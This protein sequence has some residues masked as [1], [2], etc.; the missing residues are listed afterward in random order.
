M[1]DA[2]TFA[3]AR[4]A[5]LEIALAQIDG[6]IDKAAALSSQLRPLAADAPT[7]IVEQAGRA[8]GETPPGPGQDTRT[9]ERRVPPAPL[10]KVSAFAQLLDPREL[11]VLRPS[12]DPFEPTR[13][14]LMRRGQPVGKAPG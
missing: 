10:P 5:E 11:R 4:R 12:K 8:A 3:I 14:S 6:F 9:A 7:D 1:A 2:L 13:Y